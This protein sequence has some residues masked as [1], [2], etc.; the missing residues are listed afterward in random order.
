MRSVRV[1][2][3]AVPT[4]YLGSPIGNFNKPQDLINFV[5]GAADGQYKEDN[6]DLAPGSNFCAP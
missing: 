1:C 6:P 5:L 2:R 4:P 3:L